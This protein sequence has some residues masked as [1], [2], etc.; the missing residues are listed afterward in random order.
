MNERVRQQLRLKGIAQEIDPG[1]DVK[2]EDE[3]GF[4]KVFAPDRQPL[5]LGENN[6]ADLDDL[7]LEQEI[8]DRWGSDSQAERS[9]MTSKGYTFELGPGNK[10][11]YPAG[12]YDR[13]TQSPRYEIEVQIWQ[14][15][16]RQVE[17]N[18]FLMGTEGNFTWCWDIEN[19]SPWPAF[20]IIKKDGV[21]V[22]S[23]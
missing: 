16:S 12:P 21:L 23:I 4:L 7:Q 22:D 14:H 2:Y 15:R 3:E 13:D 20:I 1:A 6:V 19:K 9:P 11:R 17:W 8:R 5:W 18:Q 10:T